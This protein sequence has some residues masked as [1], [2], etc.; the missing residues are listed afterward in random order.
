[1]PSASTIRAGKASVEIGGDNNPLL[2]ALD[3]SAKKL[4][5]WGGAVAKFAALQAADGLLTK[6]PMAIAAKSTG[7]AAIAM[8]LLSQR[9]NVGT[10]ELSQYEHAATQVGL[11]LADV[12]SGFD[13]LNSLTD[14]ARKRSPDAIHA[15]RTIGTTFEQWER[16]NPA[17]QLEK[18]VGA[19]DKIGN[20]H[21]KKAFLDQF[22]GDSSTL[23]PLINQ[24]AA[25]LRRLKDE[26]ESMGL[27]VKPAD[28]ATSKAMAQN[29][30]LL[31]SAGAALWRTVGFALAP[32]LRDVGAW[33]A[34]WIPRVTKLVNENRPLVVQ[35]AK[36]AALK[37][38]VGV[39]LLGLGI[40]IK[41]AGYAFGFL[42]TGA[43]LAM[44]AVGA[45]I[46]ALL[47]PVGLL[48]AGVAGLAAAWLTS[49][50]AGREAAGAFADVFAAMVDD[51]KTAMGAIATAMQGG[52]LKAAAAVAWAYIQLEWA[53][54]TG[55]LRDLWT[56]FS[57]W[58][59]Q[60]FAAVWYGAQDV[61]NEVLA[62][63]ESAWNES[64]AY[65]GNAWSL[66][67]TGILNIWT[68]V[69][70]SI[71]NVWT[72][73]T[74]AIAKSILWL[75]SKIAD[76]FGY[77]QEARDFEESMNA[78]ADAAKAIVDARNADADSTKAGRNA[79]LDAAA[80][81]REA[82]RKA[83]SEEIEKR[84]SADA[85]RIAAERKAFGEINDT[86]RDA[87]LKAQQDRVAAA[88]KD[89]AAAV[90]EANKTPGFKGRSLANVKGGKNLGESRD[91]AAGLGLGEKA[92][93]AGAFNAARAGQSVA[94]PLKSIADNTKQ[95]LSEQMKTNQHLKGMD[96]GPKWSA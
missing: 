90:D 4:K 9:T 60:M 79:A 95:M 54:G 84:R 78:A 45:A 20:F 42:R 3:N 96:A 39:A 53:R 6:A 36:L 61:F 47:S 12:A 19:A 16:L 71:A 31:R 29:W 38:A 15:L 5:A 72:K 56:R 91:E 64:T 65:L 32:A 77:E 63:L 68:S 43:M 25:G 67:T 33:L 55:A 26:A 93:I 1:M 28:A 58:F 69:T 51:S 44:K 41:A 92:G 27:A 76:L 22:F 23:A 11:T 13:R 35:L 57:S 87:A 66:A 52:N 40:G 18:V 2:R 85:A 94:A 10:R 70:T 83:N 37:V 49:T 24:G 82:R 48:L 73:V 8:D 80:A 59:A 86:D 21:V 46:A 81:E 89:F 14:E 74:S 34:Q 17:E 7:A 50:D 88:K 62:G 75:Q 30:M